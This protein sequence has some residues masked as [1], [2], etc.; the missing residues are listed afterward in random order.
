[1]VSV[2]TLVEMKAGETGRI[3]GVGGGH[4]IMRNLEGMGIRIGSRIKK[5]SQ[6]FMNGPVV[7]SH[8]NTRVAVGWGMAKRIMI[9]SELP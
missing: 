9:E 6:Q 7:L 2:R 8:G 5:I 4:G 1:M 3:V